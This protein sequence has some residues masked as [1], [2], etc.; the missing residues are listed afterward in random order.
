MTFI[1]YVVGMTISGLAIAL[2]KGWLMT[3]VIM[4]SIPLIVLSKYIYSR[5]ILNKYTKEQE[6]YSEAGGRAEE[7]LFSI[8]TVKMLNGQN[9]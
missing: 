3:I 1:L 8:K 2:S 5:L 4:G 7:A 6:Y 9:Y